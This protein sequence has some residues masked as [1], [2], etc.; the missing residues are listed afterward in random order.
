MHI[1]NFKNHTESYMSLVR[2]VGTRSCPYTPTTIIEWNSK[3][4]I[5]NN[6]N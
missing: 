2:S 5:Y 6:I 4:V 1:E 3:N